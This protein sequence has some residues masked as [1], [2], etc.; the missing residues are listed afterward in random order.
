QRAWERRAQD[1]EQTVLREPALIGVGPVEFLA[2]L[3]AR[4]AASDEES[5]RYDAEV[6][7]V[8]MELVMAHERALGARVQDV[9]SPELAL[10]AGL[11]TAWPG[12]DV[13]SHRPDGKRRCIEIKGR[14]RLGNVHISTNEWAAAA[15]RRGE[16]WLYAVFECATPAPQLVAVQD[17]FAKLV[18]KAA[19]FELEAAD[20][21]AAGEQVII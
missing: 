2:H 5:M 16:Y 7:R 21:L 8:A 6:E 1:A 12:F 13:L 20:I 19:G 14:A 9:H 18:E 10:Q 3:L 15:N 11:N 4:P 17:P